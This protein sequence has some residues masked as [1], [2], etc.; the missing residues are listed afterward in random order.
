MTHRNI[1]WGSIVLI[2]VN[3][4]AVSQFNKVDVSIDVK[5]LKE[6]DRQELAELKPEIERFFTQNVWDENW[7]D[8]NIPLSIQMVIEGVSE[9]GS[10]RTYLAQLMIS[11]GSDT[12]LFDKAVQFYYNTGTP[13]YFDVVVFDP[14]P[15]L[16]SFYGLLILGTEVDT[17]E[18]LGGTNILEKARNIANMGSNSDFPRGWG[19]RTKD[20]DQLISNYGLRKTRFAFYYGVELFQ[21]GKVE[22][23][24]DEFIELMKGLRESQLK[25]PRDPHKLYFLKVHKKE[26][27]NLFTTL[28]RKDWLNELISIDPDN[29]DVYGPALESLN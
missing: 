21:M 23:A 2:L 27:T 28:N 25:D 20:L 22:E 18:P 26:I 1:L 16:L 19:D 9:K 5:F 12:R 4:I 3:S 8:L 6:S 14:L 29:E 17:Y 10:V 24:L 13:M 15:F 11:G 7:N